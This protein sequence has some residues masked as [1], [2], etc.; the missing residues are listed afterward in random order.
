MKVLWLHVGGRPE[1]CRLSC[2]PSYLLRY[3]FYLPSVD[4]L[5]RPWRIGGHQ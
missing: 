4:K 3:D 2:L 1:G 5:S